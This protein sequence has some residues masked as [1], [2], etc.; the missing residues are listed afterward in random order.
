MDEDNTA[1]GDFFWDDG[2]TKD[3]IENGNYI[4]YTFSVSN[5]TLNIVCTHSSYQEGTTLAFQ[6]IK[7]LGLVETVTEV[8]VMGDNQAMQD[9]YNFTYDASNQNLLIYNFTFNLGRNFTVQWNQVI[10]QCKIT[11]ISLMMLPIRIF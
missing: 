2:E 8:K 7:I 11:T 4:L 9:H 5:N 1:I 6:T 10:K 3:T